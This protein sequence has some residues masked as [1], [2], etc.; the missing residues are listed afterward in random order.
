MDGSP[1][2]SL[3]A[4]RDRAVSVASVNQKL[5]EKIARLR[6]RNRELTEEL[7][8][9]K[10][11]R[12]AELSTAAVDLVATV[13]T[14]ADQKDLLASPRR[15]APDLAPP[16]PV[17]ASPSQRAAPAAAPDTQGA[18]AADGDIQLLVR[19]H[20]ANG[21]EERGVLGEVRCIME[22][23]GC[24]ATTRAAPH[25][26]DAVFGESFLFP[27]DSVAERHQ[28]RVSLVSAGSSAVD[29][30][31]GGGGEWE[32]VGDVTVAFP[33][34][35]AANVPWTRAFSMEHDAGSLKL[36]VTWVSTELMSRASVGALHQQRKIDA[37]RA[38][39][40]AVGAQRDTPLVTTAVADAQRGVGEQVRLLLRVVSRLQGELLAA[41]SA[42]VH[43]PPVVVAGAGAVDAT[44]A[45][46]SLARAMERER[47]SGGEGSDAVAAARAEAREGAAAAAA[48]ATAAAAA[49]ADNTAAVE[50]KLATKESQLF[51]CLQLITH[52]ESELDDF[53]AAA[54][55]AAA[56]AAEEEVRAQEEAAAAAAA[57][58]AAA[59]RRRQVVA[60]REA[61]KS[62]ARA[63]RRRG[64]GGGGG[65]GGGTRSK[66][67]KSRRSEQAARRVRTAFSPTIGRRGTVASRS[68]G[69]W[70]AELRPGVRTVQ[71]RPP[72]HTGVGA[73]LAANQS[74][75]DRRAR[76]RA[77]ERAREAQLDGAADD[78][79]AQ[80]H[81]AAARR[82]L[83]SGAE[84]TQPIRRQGQGQAQR[85]ASSRGR[86]RAR[87]EGRS[88]RGQYDTSDGP[89]ASVGEYR[90]GAPRRGPSGSTAY[91]SGEAYDLGSEEEY[92]YCSSPEEDAVQ[93]GASD[94]LLASLRFEQ[95]Q[96]AEFRASLSRRA[97]HEEAAAEAAM[98]A[99]ASEA[100]QAV[101]AMRARISALRAELSG[102]AVPPTLL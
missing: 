19:V 82:T 100:L 14:L 64:G 98:E 69:P 53:R 94:L 89:T 18:G 44:A 47:A 90:R 92:A 11:A 2:L 31:A 8:L 33:A 38:T 43:E 86:G 3:T 78:C 56:A 79:D 51:A 85:L 84:R 6:E 58:A 49:A 5:S 7:E 23:A 41:K 21:L 24:T 101:F 57:T 4:L 35:P 102:G 9:E 48:A 77:Y 72:M 25:D 74:A 42:G 30:R 95:E 26:R 67:E 91:E 54:A 15:A 12:G 96:N 28:L 17:F 88:Q 22:C 32:L 71:Q 75:I 87:G 1:L 63:R 45:L 55:A 80:A 61:N 99:E 97:S 93:A 62:R 40:A 76:A 13:A 10:A 39:A 27:I 66:K 37:L 68:R 73:G 60:V 29:L 52:Q 70:A 34:H 81:L 65:G 50:A 83:G 46:H 36:T 59:P 20:S 16:P